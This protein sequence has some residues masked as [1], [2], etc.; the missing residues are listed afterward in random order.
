MICRKCN[1][2]IPEDAV[3][4][5]LCGTRQVA[6]E[7][8][9]RKR[10]NGSGTIAK[11]AGGRSKPWMARKAGILIG[12]YSTRYEA[13]KAL[14]AL[15]NTNVN[16]RYNL[17]FAEIYALWLPEHARGIGETAVGNYRTAY[18]HCE[19]LYDQRFRSLRA[20]N[21]GHSSRGDACFRRK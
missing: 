20:S 9:H 10:P 3:F 11:L 1:K 15:S 2:E 7:R 5:H 18:N 4:C 16:D 21:F 19:P 13:Q 12:T 8:K 6:A 14:D 17:T